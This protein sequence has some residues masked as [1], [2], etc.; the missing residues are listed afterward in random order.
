MSRSVSNIYKMLDKY[1]L[2]DWIMNTM[3]SIILDCLNTL[4][5]S[6][7]DINSMREGIILLFPTHNTIFNTHEYIFSFFG[8]SNKE[9]HSRISAEYP[10]G[11]S[12]VLESPSLV[13]CPLLFIQ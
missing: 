11:L 9:W 7:N 3:L 13:Y 5:V 12:H 8:K 1:L 2:K 4:I 10:L 6:F